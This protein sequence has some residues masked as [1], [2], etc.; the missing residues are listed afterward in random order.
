MTAAALQLI[1]QSVGLLV[2]SLDVCIDYWYELGMYE[3]ELALLPLSINTPLPDH[4]S[5]TP[6]STTTN[7]PTMGASVLFVAFLF[8]IPSPFRIASYHIVVL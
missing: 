5:S 7:Q 6:T 3:H 4:R 1:R 2:G 8:P